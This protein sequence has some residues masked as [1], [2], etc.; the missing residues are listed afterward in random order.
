MHIVFFFPGF[1]RARYLDYT[2]HIFQSVRTL[3]FLLHTLSHTFFGSSLNSFLI[4]SVFTWFSLFLPLSLS[5]TKWIFRI[6]YT[7]CLTRFCLKIFHFICFM[8][9]HLSFG[10]FFSCVSILSPR[11]RFLRTLKRWIL[12]FNSV[13]Y[14]LRWKGGKIQTKTYNFLSP[15]KLFLMVNFPKADEKQ[16][17]AIIKLFIFKTSDREWKKTMIQSYL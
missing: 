10:H 15:T 8:R 13:S 6:I 4:C 5:N 11:P 1:E 3:F 16:T 7:L 2:L 17:K 14:L 9:S 12:H